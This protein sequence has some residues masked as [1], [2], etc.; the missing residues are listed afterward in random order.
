MLTVNEK[1]MAIADAIRDKTSG[2]DALTLDDMAESIPKVYDAGKKSQYD[3]FW[4]SY[5]ENGTCTNYNY[6]FYGRGWTNKT[7]NPKYDSL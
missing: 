1:M 2:T 5:Q 6:A 4:D 7:F 3:E